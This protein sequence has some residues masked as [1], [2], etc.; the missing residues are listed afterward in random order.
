MLA[1]EHLRNAPFSSPY[2]PSLMLSLGFQNTPICL[3]FV[4]FVAKGVRNSQ[5]S[6][7]SSSTKK[8]VF[9]KL[10][11]G[12]DDL[13]SYPLFNR[14]D[15]KLSYNLDLLIDVTFVMYILLVF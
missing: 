9:V 12:T 7:L 3:C 2:I 8:D 5:P 10:K 14:I 6:G 4:K 11:L 13:P 1:S 15:Y